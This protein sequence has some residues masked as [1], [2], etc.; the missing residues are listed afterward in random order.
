MYTCMYI[1]YLFIIINVHT[2]IIHNSKK[3]QYRYCCTYIHYVCVYIHVLYQLSS[4]HH[5]VSGLIYMYDT[6][7]E[8]I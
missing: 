6:V 1:L 8:M 2:C 7:H 3:K 5:V 4:A